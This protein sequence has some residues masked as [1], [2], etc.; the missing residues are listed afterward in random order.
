MTSPPAAGAKQN[1]GHTGGSDCPCKLCSRVKEPLIGDG[2]LDRAIK[3][4]DRKQPLTEVF[5][6]VQARE[7]LWALQ[8]LR[9]HRDRE[10]EHYWGEDDDD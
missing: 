9:R 1:L 3:A 10:D 2:K 5:K 6:G 8:E 4:L 7:L